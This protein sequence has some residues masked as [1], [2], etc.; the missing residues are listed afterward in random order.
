M[1]LQKETA[2]M[3]EDVQIN[4]KKRTQVFTH[5]TMSTK[6]SPCIKKTEHHQTAP[7]LWIHDSTHSKHE[8]EAHPP[9]F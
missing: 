2:K 8:A 4:G 1:L 9:N 6:T 7:S 5:K 3:N